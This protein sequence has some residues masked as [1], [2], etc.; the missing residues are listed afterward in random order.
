M[1]FIH[2]HTH[3]HYSLLDGLSKIDELVNRAKELGM[4]ALALTDHG[5]MYGA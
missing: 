3:S 2:L 5:V 4:E 1:R